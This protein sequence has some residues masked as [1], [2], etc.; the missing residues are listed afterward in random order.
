M[1]PRKRR[2]NR[3][4]AP[5]VIPF[6]FHGATS[7][8]TKNINYSDI[9]FRNTLSPF[10][11]VR[12]TILCIYGA[13]PPMPIVQ[14]NMI[15]A[16]T[17]TDIITLSPCKPVGSVNVRFNMRA[18]RFTDY[19]TS[20]ANKPV[21]QMAITNSVSGTVAFSGTV[22]IQMGPHTLATKVSIAA[23]RARFITDDDD[24][25]ADANAGVSQRLA[26]GGGST[27]GEREK[28]S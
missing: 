23:F 7:A 24:D 3:R 13:T 12:A 17:D 20:A 16:M 11:V 21:I 27:P 4:Q 18:P 1:A 22:W 6:D 28:T 8:S 25:E 19:A 5:R 2:G 15:S 10:R 26:G 9:G 14:M